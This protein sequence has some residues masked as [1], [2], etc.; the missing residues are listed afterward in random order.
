MSKAVL[1]YYNVIIRHEDLDTL[2]DGEWIADTIVEFHEEYLERTVLHN[3]KAIK[4]L[5][6]SMVYLVANIQ[7]ASEL[8]SALPPDLSSCQ[9]VF[10]PVNDAADPTR[11]DSGSHWSLLV[12]ARPFNSFYYYDSLGD[13]N[14][15]AALAVAKKFSTLL[16][17]VKPN[18]VHQ[19]DGPQQVNGADCGACV[20]GA[21]DVLVNRLLQ[22]QTPG[23][24]F[25]PD[26]IMHLTENDVLPPATVRSTLKNI[27]MKLAKVANST[28][29]TAIR[30][31][32]S[33]PVSTA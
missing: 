11:A 16:S 18:F 22:P 5:R 26:A 24:A 14:L 15:N 29:G 10:I 4:L 33:V 19:K 9:A 2:N 7:D 32:D 13:S 23:T 3:T 21:T 17:K 27:I 28:P 6:P 8:A 31:G 20:I 30:A 12:Y 1:E 25:S